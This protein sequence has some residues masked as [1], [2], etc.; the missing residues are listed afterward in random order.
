MKVRFV[1]KTKG[2]FKDVKQIQ[3]N[4]PNNTFFSYRAEALISSSYKSPRLL[5]FGLNRRIP[6][7]LK[8]L[9]FK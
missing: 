6:N 2:F 5:T 1:C 4:S 7:L 9:K 3:K 8:N